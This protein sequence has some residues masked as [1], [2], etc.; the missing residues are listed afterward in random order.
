MKRICLCQLLCYLHDFPVLPILHCHVD[1]EHINASAVLDHSRMNR[2]SL[3]LWYV[4]LSLSLY[5]FLPLCCWLGSVLGS[6]CPQN[7]YTFACI[8]ALPWLAFYPLCRR[9]WLMIRVC[10]FSQQ[11]S[12]PPACSHI[13][14]PNAGK[15]FEF[16]LP[17]RK[18]KHMLASTQENNI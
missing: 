7:E 13:K 17:R 6:T 4:L 8:R 10:H 5:S 11:P 1:L 16:H 9:V 18:Q 14:H 12:R 2:P 3:E 15:N